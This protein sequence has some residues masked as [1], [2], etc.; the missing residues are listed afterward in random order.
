MDTFQKGYMDIMYNGLKDLANF[1]PPLHETLFISD[2][3]QLL[4]ISQQLFLTREHTFVHVT[5]LAL[6]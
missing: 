2:Y 5:K 4:T 6:S 1:H 3:S